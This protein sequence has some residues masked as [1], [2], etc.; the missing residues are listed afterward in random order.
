MRVCLFVGF[1]GFLG[2]ICRYLLS[3]IPLSEKTSFPVITLTIN[4][5]G[6]LLIGVVAGLSQK[7]PGLNAE[8]ITFLRVGIIGGFTTFS[9]FA[10]EATN[11]IGSGK[12]WT[13]S[14]YILLS[15]VLGVGAV[16]FGK[17]L[18]A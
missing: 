9:T 1:G 14:L 7:Y 16:L 2:T 3:L 18:A 5:V 13:C 15:L 12:L 4:V 6:A 17:M 10:L 11:L 8:W